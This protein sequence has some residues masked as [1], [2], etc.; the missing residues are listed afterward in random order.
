MP[1]EPAGRWPDRTPR[2]HSKARRPAP[3]GERHW[4]P[5]LF[6]I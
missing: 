2:A 1:A 3:A 5:R 6:S 4:R